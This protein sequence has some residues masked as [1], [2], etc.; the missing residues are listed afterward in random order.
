MTRRRWIADEFFAD[1]AALVGEHA[2]DLSQVLRAQV[3]QEFEIS[4]AGNV[5]MGRIARISPERVEFDLGDM[6]SAPAALPLTVAIS[7]FKFDRMEWA[8]EKCTELRVARIVPLVSARTEAHLAT[9]AVKRVDRWRRIA[10]QA[11]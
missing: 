2:R 1:E 10:Q 11:S 3:G 4:V 5:R 9:A 6:V 8:L 7:V